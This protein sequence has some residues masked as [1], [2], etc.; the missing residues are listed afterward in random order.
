MNLPAL[1][2]PPIKQLDQPQR[3]MINGNVKQ[4]LKS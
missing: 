3:D 4:L 1:R 2:P